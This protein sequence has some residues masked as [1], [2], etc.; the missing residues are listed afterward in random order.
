MSYVGW[1]D[2]ICNS[3]FGWWVQGTEFCGYFFFIVQAYEFYLMRNPIE[4]LNWNKRLQQTTNLLLHKIQFLLQFLPYGRESQFKN[5]NVFKILTNCSKNIYKKPI[6]QFNPMT[7]KKKITKYNK[8]TTKT[9]LN[10]LHFTC[11]P[12]SAKKK[13]LI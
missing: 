8:I 4:I 3:L 1:R 5:K 2:L 11:N 9:V 7:N 13:K 12:K 6:N 10:R